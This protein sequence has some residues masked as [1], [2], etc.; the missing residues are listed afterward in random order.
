MAGDDK[1]V[2]D[3]KTGDEGEALPDF[4]E[5]EDG[6]ED[7][8]A[9]DAEATEGAAADDAEATEDAAADDAAADDAGDGDDAAADDAAADDSAADDTA[10]DDTAAEDS[11]A[12]DTAAEDSAGLAETVAAAPEPVSEPIATDGKKK[13]KKKKGKPATADLGLAASKAT[14]A[15]SRP[16][17]DDEEFDPAV[18]VAPHSD[19]IFDGKEPTEAEKTWEPDPGFGPVRRSM[20]A[21]GVAVACGLGIVGHFVLIGGDEA[22]S[23]EV[24]AFV[25]GSIVEFKTA[26]VERL[27][28]KWRR[29]DQESTNVYGD[30]TLTYFPADARLTIEQVTKHQDGATWGAKSAEMKEVGRK[31]IPNKTTELK[32]GQTIERL[33]LMNLPIFESDKAEDG[34][35]KAVYYYDYKVTFT[36][37]G[38]HPQEK[39]W[40]EDDWQRVGPGNRIIPWSGLD[41]VPKPETIKENFAKS[42]GEIFCLMKI[43]DYKTVQDASGDENFDMLLLRNRIKTKEDFDAAFQVLTVG[44]HA[45]WWKVQQDA[46]AKQECPGAEPAKKGK[47]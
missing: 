18:W 7:A 16:S 4:I 29:E 10:A 37:E 25:D 42:M 14:A 3:D 17:A 19:G 6:A 30:V 24:Q 33:P 11:A 21:L 35:V 36:R 32:E 5:T 44:E 40:R 13:K 8:A 9:D 46:I 41:L 43:K 27:K 20:I 12:E 2:T 38:Y 31:P 15:P 45:E 26:E 34:S 39:T 47:K 22:R 1:T 28:K 23:Q